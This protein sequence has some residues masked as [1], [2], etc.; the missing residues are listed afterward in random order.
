MG[1]EGDIMSTFEISLSIQILGLDIGHIFRF[2]GRADDDITWERLVCAYLDEITDSDIFPC[3][4]PPVWFGR[5]Y[6]YE[7]VI[8]G[9]GLVV[10]IG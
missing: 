4:G 6:V 8:V 2:G 10:R 1:E 9:G 7:I 3:G 5:V